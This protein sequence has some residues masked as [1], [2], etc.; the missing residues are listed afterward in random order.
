[1]SCR[2]ISKSEIKP[3]PFP[4]AVGSDLY[5]ADW[6]IHSPN[7]VLRFSKFTTHAKGHLHT[8]RHQ[9]Q[10]NSTNRHSKTAAENGKL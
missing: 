1:M 9:T 7:R 10:K 6:G 4:L 5:F 2:F 3:D 8:M